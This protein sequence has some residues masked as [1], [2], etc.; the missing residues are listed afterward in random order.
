VAESRSRSQRPTFQPR[1]RLGSSWARPSLSSV[2]LSELSHFHTCIYTV[3]DSNAHRLILLRS[4]SFSDA[5][6]L[7]VSRCEW[8]RAPWARARAVGLELV[9]NRLLFK[10]VSRDP[11][12][13]ENRSKRSK[14]SIGPKEENPGNEGVAA[15]A[16]SRHHLTRLRYTRFVASCSGSRQLRIGRD[17]SR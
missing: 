17:T 6:K 11:K 9:G 5:P 15:F 16:S 8:E 4:V 14:R 3:L 12:S 2:V 10:S 1:G 7:D 13:V